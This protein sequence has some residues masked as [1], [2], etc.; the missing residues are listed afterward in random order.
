M[1]KA[2]RKALAMR[3][4]D[5]SAANAHEVVPQQHGISD[6]N[7]LKSVCDV[8]ISLSLTIFVEH[9]GQQGA[10]SFY[11]AAFGAVQTNAHF[12]KRRSE[13]MA[14][15]IRLGDRTISV[16]GAN[17]RRE[18]EPLRGGPFFPKEPGSVS[19]TASGGREISAVCV[20]A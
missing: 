13:L 10:A 11:Q 6:G 12:L 5:L 1:A 19:T 9:G 14:V 17:P 20:S 2:L 8:G 7:V 15:D 16:C 4:I 3:Q 18:T